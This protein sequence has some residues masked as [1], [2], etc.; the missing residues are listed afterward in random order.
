MRLRNKHRLHITVAGNQE[1][2]PSNSISSNVLDA[3]VCGVFD[4][5]GPKRG[6]LFA[7][8]QDNRKLQWSPDKLFD[9]AVSRPS[10]IS[11]DCI[12]L[13]L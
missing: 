8:I 1:Q 6:L 5:S 11:G 10:D 9:R 7:R 2:N 4:D 12:E 13:R 3:G